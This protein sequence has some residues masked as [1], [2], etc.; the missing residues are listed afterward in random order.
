MKIG[1]LIIPI[2]LW[3]CNQSSI[4]DSITSE[5]QSKISDSTIVS[6]S[7][8]KKDSTLMNSNQN[9]L[10]SIE[11]NAIIHTIQASQL[12]IEIQDSFNAN[13]QQ[14]ILKIKNLEIGKIEGIIR[15]ENE[16]MNIRFNQIKLPDNELDGPFEREISYDIKKPRE[17]WLIVG[18]SNMAS[19]KEDGK[20]T[21]QIS[22]K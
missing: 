8:E 16:M 14:L 21:I 3:S 5:S 10:R 17:V 13:Q 4:S 1:F 22:K 15:P 19:G 7:K 20:F 12:P 11:G 2:C 6:K 18:K 9:G